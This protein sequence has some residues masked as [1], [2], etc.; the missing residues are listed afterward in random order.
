[1][2]EAT[3]WDWESDDPHFLACAEEPSSTRTDRLFCASACALQRT[4][5]AAAQYTSTYTRGRAGGVRKLTYASFWE[6]CAIPDI[7]YLNTSSTSLIV[8]GDEGRLTADV[9]TRVLL[10]RQRHIIYAGLWISELYSYH[11][12]RWYMT[13][14]T[15]GTARYCTFA[16][17]PSLSCLVSLQYSAFLSAALANFFSS[18]CVCSEL[19]RRAVRS[20]TMSDSRKWNFSSEST[21]LLSNTSTLER[22]KEKHGKILTHRMWPRNLL[23]VGGSSI[24]AWK[25]QDLIKKTFFR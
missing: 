11:A 5:P 3:E 4:A 22:Q 17:S 23:S 2:A 8:H 16:L 14:W 21:L 6:Q 10:Y 24:N 15:W 1:M 25:C 20:C 9:C 18:S 12:L 19:M 7:K 13:E